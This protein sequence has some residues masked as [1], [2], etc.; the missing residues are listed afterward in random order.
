MRRS[1]YIPTAALLMLAIAGSPAVANSF[2]AR[3]QAATIAGTPLTVTPPRDWNRLGATVGKKTETWTLDG[4]ELND[5]TFFAGIEV[6]KPLM[7]E[8]HK[9]RAPL[10]KLRRNTLLVEIPE[11]LEGTYRAQR[12]IATFT[13]SGTRPDRFLGHDGI[14]FTFDYVDGDELPRRGEGVATLIHGQLYMATFSAPHLHYYDR[15]ITEFHALVDSA[16]MT[17]TR[18]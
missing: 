5:V 15:T 16:T 17:A 14:R 4:E 9:K 8:A 10:P 18:G 3:G 6:G 2:R 1:T 12:G 7:K 13:V 11:L